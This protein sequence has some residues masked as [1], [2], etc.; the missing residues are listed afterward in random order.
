MM[1]L[2]FKGMNT[3]TLTKE[4]CKIKICVKMLPDKKEMYYIC[5]QL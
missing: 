3:C 5:S 2:V 4:L 1:Q